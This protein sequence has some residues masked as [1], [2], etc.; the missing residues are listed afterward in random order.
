MLG[1]LKSI[2]PFKSLSVHKAK[3]VDEHLPML[4]EAKHN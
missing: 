1:F 4:L 3:L 2:L